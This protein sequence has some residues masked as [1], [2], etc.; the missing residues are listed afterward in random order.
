M[1]IHMSVG[2]F[3]ILICIPWKCIQKGGKHVKTLKEELSGVGDGVGDDTAV[4]KDKL[5]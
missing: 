1:C 5:K 4:V 2:S 3:C